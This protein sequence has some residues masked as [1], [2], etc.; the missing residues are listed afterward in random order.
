M[1]ERLRDFDLGG[2]L[3]EELGWDRHQG[4]T[5]TIS[6]KEQHF[7]ATPIAEK[8]GFVVWRCEAGDGRI[9]SHSVRRQ[10]ERRITSLAFEHLIVFV[11]DPQREQVW[12]WVKRE[13]GKPDASREYTYRASQTGEPVLQRLQALKFG[14]DEEED[15]TISHVANRVRGALNAEK[16]TKRFY[17]HF[18]AELKNFQGFI[19]GIGAA[20]DVEWYASLTL[21]RL[22]FIYFIQKRG[23]LDGDPDYLRNRLVRV[24]EYRGPDQF[25]DFYRTFL[26]RLFH[27]GL[28][29]P[30]AERS[31]GLTALLGKVP[32]LNG[33]IF[34]IHDLERDNPDIRIPDKAFEQL[35]DLFDQYAWHLDERP[36]ARDNEINPDVLGHIFEKSINQKEKGAYYTKE[37]ITAYM[38]EGTIIPRLLDMATVAA[39]ASNCTDDVF[40]PL[41]EDPDRYIRPAVG[42]G[43]AWDARDTENPVRV[44][45]PRELPNDINAGIGDPTKRSNWDQPAYE[46]K[47]PSLVYAHA[48]ESWRHV[49]ARRQRYAE[50]CEKLAS[51]GVG[52]ASDLVTLN[53]DGQRLILDVIERTAPPKLVWAIWRA[54]TSIS[55]LD[56]TCGSGA[57]LFAALKVLEP[58]YTACLIRMRDLRPPG[59]DEVLAELDRHASERY[60]I[61]KSIVLNNLY[62]VDIMKEA[63]EIC[64]LRLFLKLVAQLESYDQI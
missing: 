46:G 11:D 45:P 43:L 63:V 14:L 56:P 23:F 61:L 21:N 38:A 44:D 60:F 16:V 57:F 8:R 51:G 36:Y 18:Q 52:D 33:G 3:V 20:A 42:H 35:F 19:E 12:Q 5:V 62:G 32:F 24:R 59:A 30:E 31:P 50:V 47:G 55:I 39:R 22:M 49:V 54:A 25:H 17:S 4:S 58:I 2:L 48:R 7:R 9:P 6:V 34:D 26:R 27:E 28:G 41:G 15:L 40:R 13:T 29:R 53:L 10:V 64:K 37:D 1:R